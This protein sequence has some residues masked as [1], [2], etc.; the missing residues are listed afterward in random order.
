MIQQLYNLSIERDSRNKSDNLIEYKLNFHLYSLSLEIVTTPCRPSKEISIN[1]VQGTFV[2]QT[3]FLVSDTI[4]FLCLGRLNTTLSRTT[5]CRIRN[6]IP[7]T[8]L[9][10]HRVEH[11]TRATTPA[12]VI[13]RKFRTSVCRDSRGRFRAP[14]RLTV[15]ECRE[16]WP[17]GFPRK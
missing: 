2:Q 15:V 5:T 12:A 8:K 11:K 7:R 4:K 10:Y 13:G 14:K 16:S 6:K 17:A 9:E 3:R 1:S